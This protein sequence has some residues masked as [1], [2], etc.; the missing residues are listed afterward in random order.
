MFMDVVMVVLMDVD[1]CVSLIS[2][3]YDFRPNLFLLHLIVVSHQ[4]NF[5]PEWLRKHEATLEATRPTS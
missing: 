1:A 2:Y 5:S 3:S 4:I